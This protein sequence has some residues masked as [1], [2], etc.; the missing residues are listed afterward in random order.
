M[1]LQLCPI[2][3]D[4]TY[5]TRVGTIL[6]Q[7]FL[8]PAKTTKPQRQV[9]PMVPALS[10]GELGRAVSPDTIHNRSRQLAWPLGPHVAQENAMLPQASSCP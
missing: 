4:H 9:G 2:L 5:A 1:A 10:W 3:G 6:G 7:R 8:L